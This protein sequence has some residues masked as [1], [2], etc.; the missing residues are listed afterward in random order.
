MSLPGTD[1]PPLSRLIPMRSLGVFLLACMLFGPG[2]VSAITPAGGQIFDFFKEWAAV[3]N[4]QAEIPVY[5]NQR[6]A[7]ER[8]LGIT[9]ADNPG[10]FDEYNTHPPSANLIAVPFASMSYRDAHRAWN[11]LSL[12]FLA[13]TIWLIGWQ[14][15]TPNGLAGYLVAMSALLVCDPLRQSLFQGQ[16]NLLLGLLISGAWV[17][18]RRDRVGLAG[19]LLAVAS[20]IKIYP[21][22][23]F[24]YFLV[25]RRWWAFTGGLC[26]AAIISAATVANFGIQCYR[27]YFVT[28]LPALRGV[29]N[30]W[31]N[32]SVLAFW[33]RLFGTPTS[34][35]TT[36]Y[37][38]PILLR[39]CVLGSIGVLLVA[40]IVVIRRA[41]T[42]DDR[43]VAFCL[44]MTAMLLASPTTWSHYFIILPTV[45]FVALR[46]TAGR[47]VP[48]ITLY[49][50]LTALTLS[51]R[52]VWQ[53]VFDYAGSEPV[54]VV[55]WQALTAMSYQTYALLAVMIVL[56]ARRKKPET[57][58]GPKN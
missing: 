54:T 10:F 28:A 11:L 6:I 46:E 39:V 48:R 20:V 42:R 29:T 49:L 44:T 40:L 35:I 26:G 53:R 47:P 5:S 31:G 8:H 18:D 38:S 21:A 15:E 4:R 25:R 32:T 12:I 9:L 23:I 27:D 14:V 58:T 45:V 1:P 50:A 43:D 30:N 24:L 55:P 33:E 51:P 41:R 16:P 34:V 57:D 37:P 3:R 19:A 22:F 36:L 52:L 13:A 56:R 17:A 2:F 7:V